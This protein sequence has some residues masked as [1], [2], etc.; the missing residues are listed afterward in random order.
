ML[1]FRTCFDSLLV[2][3]RLTQWNTREL[4]KFNTSRKQMWIM[5]TVAMDKADDML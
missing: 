2:T 1:C 4:R 5:E 3:Q